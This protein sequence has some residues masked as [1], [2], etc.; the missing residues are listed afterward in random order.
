MF[1]IEK[2]Q[3][4]Q[5]SGRLCQDPTMPSLRQG[6]WKKREE[7]V[8]FEARLKTSATFPQDSK[9]ELQQ[10]VFEKNKTKGSLPTLI[11]LLSKKKVSAWCFIHV[12]M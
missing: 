10:R 1:S 8:Y 9:D 5:N 3:N 4:K 2:K 6:Y 7:K 12:S 11:H